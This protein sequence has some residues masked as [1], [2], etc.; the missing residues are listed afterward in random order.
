[1]IVNVK[2]LTVFGGSLLSCVCVGLHTRLF[3]SAGSPL[4]NDGVS[5]SGRV[6]ES[7]TAA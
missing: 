2:S 3:I 4:Q 6:A 7:A 5:F 1:M